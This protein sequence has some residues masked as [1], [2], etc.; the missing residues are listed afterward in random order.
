MIISVQ[1]K[2]RRGE[3]RARQTLKKEKEKGIGEES[4]SSLVQEFP[5]NLIY[6]RGRPSGVRPK[7][8]CSVGIASR[9]IGMQLIMHRQALH[10]WYFSSAQEEN[11]A[12]RV[13]CNQS[14]VT[15]RDTLSRAFTPE[16]TRSPDCKYHKS[17]SSHIVHFSPTT[18]CEERKI[19][20][21]YYIA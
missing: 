9:G 18:V 3:E 21:R 11:R 7:L 12:A 8:H 10:M 5:C 13:A 14:H 15:R 19:K 1:R 16:D 4:D 2:G 20:F 17:H 6:T